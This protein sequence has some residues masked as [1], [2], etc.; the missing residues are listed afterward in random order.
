[1]IRLIRSLL[2][3]FVL[4]SLFW[5]SPLAGVIA[6]V[7]QPVSNVSLNY[8]FGSTLQI[9]AEI[10]QPEDF[11][12][13][14]LIIQP[15]GQSPRQIGF[16]PNPSGFIEIT[17]DLKQD[18]LKPFARIY[19]WFELIKLDGTTLSTASFWFDYLDDRLSWQSNETEL[20]RIS[21]V[22]GD[23]A[24]GQKLQDVARE[25]LKKATSI[26]PLSPQL[27]IH[28]YVYPKI[29]ELQQALTL[30]G[31]SWTAGHASPEIGVI[32]V[33]NDNPSTEVIEM[34]RQIPHEL[35]HILEYQATGE[36]YADIPVWLSEGLATSAE[37]Y[38]NPDL[39]RILMEGYAAG[40]LFSI[41][42][43]CAGFP[44]DARSAQL[45]YAQSVSF[46]NYIK[47]RFGLQVFADLLENTSF[48]QTCVN[49]ISSTLNISLTQ[50]EQDWLIATFEEP[51]NDLSIGKFIPYF[52]SGGVLILAVLIIFLRTRHPRERK[53]HD[54]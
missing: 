6:Q 20:F 46:V 31:Q 21:W 36:H 12:S 41:E 28:I 40:Q 24:F 15:D 47:D 7:E 23:A 11:S 34:E 33:S 35:M 18:S 49:S 27:P 25:G 2:S 51:K 19:Y 17:Y 5:V 38:P 8:D 32:L 22:E 26:L 30:T 1:M 9:S 53:P 42:S 29:E 10:L 52:I 16:T 37:L 45:A 13:Y 3:L 43:L 4:F 39:Q 50:L 48:G 54:Q 14:V 44:Q